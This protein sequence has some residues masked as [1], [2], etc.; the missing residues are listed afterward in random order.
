[1]A[2]GITKEKLWEIRD[3][4]AGVLGEDRVLVSADGF[5]AVGQAQPSADPIARLET[6]N[7]PMSIAPAH[8]AL[9]QVD[10]KTVIKPV[11]PPPHFPKQV[12]KRASGNV[13]E[14]LRAYQ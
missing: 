7:R 11:E 13:Y 10:T 12:E 3:I 14:S 8:P 5:N 4:L 2:S 1:L 6:S 9:V